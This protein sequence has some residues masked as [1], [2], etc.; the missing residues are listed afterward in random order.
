M[1]RPIIAVALA[2][3]TSF[4]LGADAAPELA[5]ARRRYETA[6]GIATKQVRER[7][8]QELQQLKSRAMSAKNL[9]LAVAV[10]GE[11]KSISEQLGIKQTVAPITPVGAPSTKAATGADKSPTSL[12]SF[13]GVGEFQAW[14]LTTEW[15]SKDGKAVYSFPAPGKMKKIEKKTASSNAEIVV[16]IKIPRP[17][18]ISWTWSSGT[19]V[20]MVINRDLKDGADSSNKVIERTK[21]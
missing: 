21:P 12:K 3:I 7:Y 20:V 2:L 14:L 15:T 19:T 4:C 17:G 6:L 10:E 9:D 18:E 1:K 13:P 8:L 5:A 16:D 11:A